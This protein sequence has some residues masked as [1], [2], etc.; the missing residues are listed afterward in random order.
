MMEL[1]LFA[2]LV[3]FAMRDVY[4]DSGREGVEQRSELAQGPE[5]FAA[6]GS[7]RLHLVA[8]LAD[9]FCDVWHFW[10]ALAPPQRRGLARR[11]Y[12]P[13]LLSGAACR[14]IALLEHGLDARLAALDLIVAVSSGDD[15]A[16]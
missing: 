2:G 15:A 12:R 5:L 11:G 10:A 13:G 7:V 4:S 8:L 16:N 14:R 9:F 1:R 3:L 6:A